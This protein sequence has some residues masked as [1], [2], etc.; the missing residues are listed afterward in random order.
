MASATPRPLSRAW[1][2]ADTSAFIRPSS[3]FARSNLRPR[4]KFFSS[5]LTSLSLVYISLCW[6]DG[7]GLAVV[8]V[9]VDVVVAV[10]LVAGEA[11]AGP[12]AGEG[13][14]EG[15]GKGN[16]SLLST[17]GTSDVDDVGS[18]AS[19]SSSLLLSSSDPNSS[20]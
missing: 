15:E 16:D 19:S 6:I 3:S 4:A 20:S 12:G 1:L 5:D 13:E 7:D 18:D 10:V 14:G 17:A 2:Y 11:G 9:V 8:R